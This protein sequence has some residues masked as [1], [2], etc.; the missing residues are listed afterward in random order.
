LIATAITDPDERERVKGSFSS[1]I[2]EIIRDRKR[3]GESVDE[4]ESH[5]TSLLAPPISFLWRIPNCKLVWWY[6]LER[7]ALTGPF[8]GMTL[9]MVYS[10][11]F[12]GAE[13]FG[14]PALGLASLVVALLITIFIRERIGLTQCNLEFARI[15]SRKHSIPIEA[16][17]RAELVVN[18]YLRTSHIRV[19]TQA[20]THKFSPTMT[21][22]DFSFLLLRELAGEKV[23]SRL[24]RLLQSLLLAPKRRMFWRTSIPLAWF[25]L[26]GVLAW[27]WSASWN[28]EGF[29]PLLPTLLVGAS[30]GFFLLQTLT[31][32]HLVRKSLSWLLITFLIAL[33][34][35]G[36]AILIGPYE[37]YRFFLILLITTV[38]LGLIASLWRGRSGTL[39]LISVCGM[40]FAYWLGFQTVRVWEGKVTA[41]TTSEEVL[42][43]SH[44]MDREPLA[45]ALV[46]DRIGDYYEALIV[47]ASETITHRL[48]GEGDWYLL[49]DYSPDTL[50]VCNQYEIADSVYRSQMYLIPPSGELTQ[51][52]QEEVTGG[53]NA[54]SYS[55]PKV[56]SPERT[57]IL[58]AEEIREGS[59]TRNAPAFVKIQTQE[60]VVFPELNLY[61]GGRWVDESNYLLWNQQVQDASGSIESATLNVYSLALDSAT[62]ELLRSYPIS[63]EERLTVLGGGEWALKRRVGEGS[64]PF[65]LW[66]LETDEEVELPPSLH[67][68][69]EDLRYLSLYCDWDST[70]RLLV[71]LARMEEDQYLVLASP[72]GVIDRIP[73]DPLRSVG[74]LQISPDGKKVFYTEVLRESLEFERFPF[75]FSSSKRRVWDRE[76]NEVVTLQINPFLFSFF[77]VPSFGFSNFEWSPDSRFILFPRHRF[78]AGSTFVTEMTVADYGAW[79]EAH[80]VD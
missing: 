15:F 6:W 71:Y 28:G 8:I 75:K 46:Q 38:I 21:G 59:D 63:G 32:K 65:R 60:K 29:S 67:P 3:C 42:P 19:D 41:W 22:I 20:G 23:G 7:L 35:A 58:T 52:L 74:N 76:R 53:L 26:L 36:C 73:I 43:D 77:D 30:V 1:V 78:V 31:T 64:A 14:K 11:G 24:S 51:V 50:T 18:P 48:E 10:F 4:I 69:K 13:G 61:G 80:P 40:G 45:F 68:Q 49:Q 54:F 2:E 5:I 55:Q 12:L 72:S 33:F 66:N 9:F 39:A 25:A 70:N 44:W 62:K 57:W 56:W 79:A 47:T 37:V 16:I 17:E 34:P 27:V